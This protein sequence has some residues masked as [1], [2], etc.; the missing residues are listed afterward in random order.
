MSQVNPGWYRDPDGRPCER[1]WDGMNW[2]LET[3]PISTPSSTTNNQAGMT[4]GWKVAIAI[5]I[6]ISILILIY[7]SS[8]PTFWTDY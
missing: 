7:A 2:T 8:D 6:S 4:T 3:R 5:I 1:Y